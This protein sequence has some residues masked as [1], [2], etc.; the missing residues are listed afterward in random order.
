MLYLQRNTP[1]QPHL[2][3]LVADHARC[4]VRGRLQSRRM[5]DYM[6]DGPKVMLLAHKDE[7]YLGKDLLLEKGK[8][9]N[10]N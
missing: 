5:P 7:E 10:G 9:Q 4:K 8:L 1:T 6:P 2:Q 3:N